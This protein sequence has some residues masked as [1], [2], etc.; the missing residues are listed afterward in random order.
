VKWQTIKTWTV[1][2]AVASATAE[3]SKMSGKAGGIPIVIVYGTILLLLGY[4]V[5]DNLSIPK[6]FKSIN[7]TTELDCSR[8][9]KQYLFET[10]SEA[11][12]FGKGLGINGVHEHTAE[13]SG[14]PLYI[15]Q[16]YNDDEGDVYRQVS[17]AYMP[18]KDHS[19]FED[20]WYERC[21]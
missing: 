14:R 17:F 6:E 16:G 2:D 8:L 10:R 20:L 4:L 5:F 19:A 13:E 15:W 11:L 3:E 21:K 12:E 7:A 1:A 9:P 18:G